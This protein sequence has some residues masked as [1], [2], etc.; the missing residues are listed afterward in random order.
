MVGAFLG[1]FIVMREEYF[2]EGYGGAIICGLIILFGSLVLAGRFRLRMLDKRREAENRQLASAA[3][4]TGGHPRLPG[5][6][7]QKNPPDESQRGWPQSIFS[8]SI[9][10]LGLLL[11]AVGLIHFIL[12]GWTPEGGG[13]LAAIILG[14][15]IA[16]VQLRPCLAAWRFVKSQLAL[17]RVEIGISPEQFRC[18]DDIYVTVDFRSGQTITIARATATLEAIEVAEQFFRHYHPRNSDEIME[19]VRAQGSQAKKHCFTRARQVRAHSLVLAEGR[20]LLPQESAGL[21][22]KISLPA[23]SPHTLLALEHKILWYLS[24]RLKL[25]D[26]LQWSRDIPVLLRA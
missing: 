24:V 21:N 18:G 20:S 14:G 4:G 25:A 7:W 8:L 10:A 9:A 3:M 1:Y 12:S 23:D 5:K 26:G 19:R 2:N 22:G 16:R 17:G 11:V 13:F 15:L 6:Y